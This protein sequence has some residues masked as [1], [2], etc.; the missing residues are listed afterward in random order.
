VDLSFNI[1]LQRQ[2]K[3]IDRFCMNCKSLTDVIIMKNIQCIL[4]SIDKQEF[5]CTL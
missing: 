4:N 5:H 3:T 2:M 1:I